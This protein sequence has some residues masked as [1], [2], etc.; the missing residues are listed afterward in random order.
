MCSSAL[1]LKGHLTFG[2]QIYVHR[3]KREDGKSNRIHILFTKSHT[4]HEKATT[5]I[6]PIHA[7]IS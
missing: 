1:L 2:L 4:V 5:T 3:E 6:A 7:T